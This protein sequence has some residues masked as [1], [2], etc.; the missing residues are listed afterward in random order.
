MGRD[1]AW[2]AADSEV[3]EVDV[4]SAESGL[5]VLLEA[6]ERA[7]E[8]LGSAIPPAQMRALLIIGGAGGLNLSRLAGALGASASATSR[9]CDRMQAAGLLTRDR[10]AA[11]R[12]EIVLVPTESGRRLA[13]WVRGRRRAALG[14]VLDRMTAEGRDALA[15]GLTELADGC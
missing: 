2:A 10:A 7:V 5:S 12:R 15:R 13:D 6:C 9:L 14:Q 1:M 3:G 4:S 8:E 11:S